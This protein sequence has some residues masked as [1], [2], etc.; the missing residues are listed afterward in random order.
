MNV[1]DILDFFFFFEEE[2]FNLI[3]GVYQLKFVKSYIVEYK[4]DDGDYN[5]MV[6]ND[7]FDVL[8]V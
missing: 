4:N 1:I 2:F 5:I 8:C 3:V 7:I 6:N